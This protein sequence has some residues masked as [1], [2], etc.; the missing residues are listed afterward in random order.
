[1]DPVAPKCP[2]CQAENPDPKLKTAYLHQVVAP[3]WKQIVFFLVGLLGLNVV[4]VISQI[5][6]QL[7]YEAGNP[8][9]TAIDIQNY[10]NSPTALMIVNAIT[11]GNIAIALG[12]IIWN[13][14]PQILRP[15]K[16]WQ[17][18]VAGLVTF[19]AIIAAEMLYNQFANLLFKAIGITPQGNT[20]QSSLVEMT[21]AMPALSLFILGFIG[22]FVEEVTYRVGLFGFLGRINKVVAY[23]GC[24][25]VFG[26]IHFNWTAL[27]NP[28]YQGQLLVELINLPPYIG[29]GAAFCFVYDRWGFGASY[30]AHS[31]NNVFSIA[32][33]LIPE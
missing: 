7:V 29:A 4:A 15:M 31:I 28:A 22:P 32:M 21:H 30:V 19:V 9:A 27:W 12:L 23:L 33:M 2:H 17:P 8:G 6:L 5:I 24:A 3:T 18:Y 14:W 16:R 1:M 11:Y 10:L 25:L 20:N 13:Q 26:F